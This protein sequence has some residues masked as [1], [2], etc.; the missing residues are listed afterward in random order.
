MSLRLPGPLV[1]GGN[2]SGGII[3]LALARKLR[4]YGS[5]PAPLM[6][7]NWQFN[8]GRY[9]GPV[10]IMQGMNGADEFALTD[11]TGRKLDWAA[12]FPKARPTVLPGRHARYFGGAPLEA[13]ASTVREQ[14]E[15][16]DAQ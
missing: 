7:L 15:G 6:L 11:T 9:E 12:D 3:A 10:V 5:E 2:C 16:A 13:F 14:T 1:L 4:Q 8:F